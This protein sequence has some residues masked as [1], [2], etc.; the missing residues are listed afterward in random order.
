[1]NEVVLP[2]RD[3]E[4]INQSRNLSKSLLVQFRRYVVA[5]SAVAEVASDKFGQTYRGKH[6]CVDLS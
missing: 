4:H 2:S 6:E 1:M 5:C 3:E